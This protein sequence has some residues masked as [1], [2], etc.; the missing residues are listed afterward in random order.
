MRKLSLLLF[1]LLFTIL[2]TLAQDMDS[3]FIRVAHFSADASTVD[4]FVN[5]ESTV[6][7]VDFA[8]LS[9]W[10]EVTAGSYTIDIVAQGGTLSDAV[11]SQTFTVAS[12]DWAT[13]ALIGEVTNSTLAFQAII[14]N[15][16]TLPDELTRIGMF[17]V[18]SELAPITVSDDSGRNLVIGL[19]YPGTF[20]GSDGYTAV[21]VAPREYTL[22]MTDSDGAN[23]SE[24][25]PTVLGAGRYYFYAAIGT[26]ESSAFVFDVTDI[27]AVVGVDSEPITTSDDTGTGNLFMRVA[28]LASDAPEVDMYLNGNLAISNLSY[29][30]MT[31]FI[32][33]EGGVYDVA[34]V[35][36][37]AALED[38]IFSGEVALFEE[39][40]T[41]VAVIGLV[42][43]E[44]LDV[45]TVQ[46][47][48]GRTGIG[49]GRIAFF[50]SIPT[51]ALFNLTV[52]GNILLQGLAFPEAFVGAGDGYVAVDIVAAEYDFAIE[53]PTVGIELDTGSITM[54]AGRYYLFVAV[55]TVDAPNYLLLPSG[56][57]E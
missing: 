33:M 46:E 21:D 7:G 44:S 50:Q 1:L 35:P 52:D 36:T 31:D 41:L 3:A 51:T 23:L 22:T 54:G 28:H 26:A 34:L 18:V 9:D 43:D 19:G 10:M 32:A 6:T 39:T 40:L 8:E 56:F 37:G 42:G 27:E 47:E 14:E 2:P 45:A 29:A 16:A 48:G 38:A 30:D 15:L 17:H 12:Q 5:G 20:E 49:E 25:G 13:I 11:L 57:P 53:S 24:I 55:G 4:V